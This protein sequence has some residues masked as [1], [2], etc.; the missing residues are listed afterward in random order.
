MASSSGTW[1]CMLNIGNMEIFQRIKL[2]DA[3]YSF[4]IL[5]ESNNIIIKGVVESTG[6]GES[7]KFW[8]E[9]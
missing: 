9:P 8:N 4:I 2:N 1:P 3:S 7:I 5:I 6:N